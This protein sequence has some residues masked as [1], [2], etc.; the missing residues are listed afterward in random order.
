LVYPWPNR[1][2]SHG[3]NLANPAKARKYPANLDN[4]DNADN[5]L[6]NLDSEFG[7]TE[8][9]AD[10]TGGKPDLPPFALSVIRAKAMGWR[11][12]LLSYEWR[13]KAGGLTC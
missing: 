1:S 2:F 10:M 8:V 11:K 6:D 7:S 9:V 12:A 13:T 4:R 3:G 5:D